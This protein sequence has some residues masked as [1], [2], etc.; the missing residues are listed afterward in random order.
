ML[1]RPAFSTHTAFITSAHSRRSRDG[2]AVLVLHMHSSAVAVSAAVPVLWQ[3]DADAKVCAR[4][5][6]RFSFVNR[7][8][9][10]RACGAV[11]CNSCSA[12]KSPIPHLGLFKPVRVCVGCLERF[13]LSPARAGRGGGA[14]AVDRADGHSAPA[15][16]ACAAAA[17]AAAV[18]EQNA[19][20]ST[21]VHPG[22]FEDSHAGRLAAEIED[23]HRTAHLKAAVAVVHTPC[24]TV[25]TKGI[26]GGYGPPSRQGATPRLHSA[27]AADRVQLQ[28]AVGVASTWWTSAP[29]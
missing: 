29:R 3:P 15:T 11:F 5:E 27:Q 24:G 20:P 8:H 13:T 25:P 18:T 14:G 23:A 10:C 7:K 17:A 12:G 16:A 9:H 6:C 2:A 28:A 21:Y 22:M 1:V 4:C 19:V 26:V